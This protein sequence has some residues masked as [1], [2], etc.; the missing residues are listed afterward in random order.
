MQIPNG[1]RFAG[2]H[3][4]IK[5]ALP[6]LALIV[7]DQPCV[8]AGVYTTNLVRA[9]CIDWNRSITP[10]ADVRAI[11]IN[12]GNANAC[13]GRQGVCD[14]AAMADGVAGALG[15]GPHAGRK[16]LVLSTGVIGRPMPMETVQRGIAMI[17]RSLASEPAAFESAATAILTT[18]HSRKTASAEFSVGGQTFRIAAMAKGAG[19]IGP[20][21]ATMLA[22]IATDYPHSPATADGAIREAVDQSFNR[23]SVEGHMSTNDAAILLAPPAN[24]GAAPGRALFQERLNAVCLELA[25]MIPTDGEG[26]THLIEIRVRGASSDQAAD[27]IARTIGL[28][29]LVKTAVAGA[30]PNWGRIVSA[31]GFAGVPFEVGQV[32][33]TINGI[34]LF[35]NGEPLPFD[36]GLTS[37]LIRQNR[38][39]LIELSVGPGPGTA[40]HYTSDL[41]ADYVRLNAEYTT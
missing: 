38:E 2:L 6:D 33:L 26:A 13:T 4:G 12:S 8:A 31:A 1:Y 28:S 34:H 40:W 37:R 27:R 20:A 3:S 24:A 15:L 21:M 39:A 35:E 9:A 29:N 25:R 17:V 30:D 41:T 16:V 22:V 23:I 19:M 32:S 36:A 5:P 11:V 10:V 18:D 14:N 7:S